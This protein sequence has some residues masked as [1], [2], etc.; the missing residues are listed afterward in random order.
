MGILRRQPLR[1]PISLIMSRAAE[2][3]RLLQRQPIPMQRRSRAEFAEER[4]GRRILAPRHPRQVVCPVG[5]HA[6][7]T[8]ARFRTVRIPAFKLPPTCD[9]WPAPVRVTLVRDLTEEI[10]AERHR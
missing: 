3:A 4:F 2:D 8:Q 6:Q 1:S 7:P 10:D 5:Q 9:W